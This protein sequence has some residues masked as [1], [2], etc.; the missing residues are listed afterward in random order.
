MSRILH[1]QRFPHDHK[2]TLFFFVLLFIFLKTATK[3][4]IITEPEVKFLC[5]PHH[6][7]QHR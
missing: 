1:N 7:F 4:E 3:K 6:E 2:V 5:F